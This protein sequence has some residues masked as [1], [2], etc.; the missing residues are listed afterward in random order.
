MSVYLYVKIIKKACIMVFFKYHQGNFK[1][2]G[3]WRMTSLVID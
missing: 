2:L 1:E 3:S